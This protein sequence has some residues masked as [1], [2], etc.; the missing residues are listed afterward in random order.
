MA[1]TAYF[2]KI[3]LVTAYSEPTLEFVLQ[4]NHHVRTATW[5]DRNQLLDFS[6]TAIT[7]VVG[8]LGR[9][10]L[11]EVW[12]SN[13]GETQDGP[14]HPGY[15]PGSIPDE[16]VQAEVIGL[17]PV[18][19]MEFEGNGGSASGAGPGKLRPVSVPVDLD[20]GGK[21]PLK[22]GA[23][24]ASLPLSDKWLWE[25]GLVQRYKGRTRLFSGQVVGLFAT[26][27]V[28]RDNGPE[29]TVVVNPLDPRTVAC[30]RTY[31]DK[32]PTEIDTL[33]IGE[34]GKVAIDSTL[35]NG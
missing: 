8:S 20:L 10:Y 3:V 18:V 5:G 11:N 23:T 33:K 26:L 6:P 32:S 21:I 1:R 35:L 16:V 27:K 4:E 7:E 31:D 14:K 25:R 15:L 24:F 28:Q 34:T 9:A 29:I 12:L 17:T 22:I 13:N 19:R 2:G 30:P